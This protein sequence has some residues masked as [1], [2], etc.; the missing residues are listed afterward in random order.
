MRVLFV[1]EFGGG[2]GHIAREVPIALELRRRGHEVLFAVRNL[3]I[4]QLILAPP[5]IDFVQAPQPQLRRRASLLP[6]H[7]RSYA[8]VLAAAG[9]AEAPALSDWLLAW[10]HTLAL[11]SPQVVVCDFSPA[12]QLAAK[13]GGYPVVQIGTGFELPPAGGRF[14]PDISP[15]GRTP[16]AHLQAREVRVMRAIRIACAAAGYAPPRRLAELYATDAPLLATLPEVDCFGPRAGKHAARYVGPLFAEELGVERH[17]HA[18]PGRSKRVF[19]YLRAEY[20]RGPEV[21]EAVLASLQASGAEVIACVPDAGAALAARYSSGAMQ[22]SLDP[23]QLKPLLKDTDLVVSNAGVGLLAQALLAGVPLLLLPHYLEQKL[24]ADAVA[25]S[26][27]AAWIPGRMV[28]QLFNE[29]LLQVLGRREYG[30]NARA[31]ARRNRALAPGR[32]AL[33]IADIIE[34]L[35]RARRRTASISNG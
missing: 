2:L 30:Q 16:A 27:V 28:R 4:G 11:I 12:A 13:L 5:G 17:W 25:R 35:G 31:I 34:R 3:E 26:G 6:R 10:K 15:S 1:W 8:D 22:V 9:F 7:Y 18:G 21:L 14:L 29:V 23:V 24:N 19:A 33:G 32:T 20:L